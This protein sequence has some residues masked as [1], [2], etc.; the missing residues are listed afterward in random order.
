[1]SNV[2]C[3]SHEDTQPRERLLRALEE[4]AA[5]R[6]QLANSGVSD[7]EIDILD[8]L[9]LDGA[10]SA[11][12][13]STHG[14]SAIMQSLALWPGRDL[15]DW[16]ELFVRL[17]EK[18]AFIALRRAADLVASAKALAEVANQQGPQHRLVL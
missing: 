12:G 15:N 10:L 9:F 18:P 7:L 11:A 1:M 4:F 14:M 3:P 6:V 8:G 13:G 5:A 17:Y 16:Q 2:P